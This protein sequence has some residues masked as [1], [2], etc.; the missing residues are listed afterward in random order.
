L[1]DSDW[2][3]ARRAEL[4]ASG[5]LEDSGRGANVA[6]G[7]V[8]FLSSLA[9]TG[10]YITF[11]FLGDPGLINRML[12][13][14]ML[15]LG[16]SYVHSSWYLKLPII[17]VHSNPVIAVYYNKF[18]RDLQLRGL[19]KDVIVATVYA[20]VFGS[21]VLLGIA[22]I[23]AARAKAGRVLQQFPPSVICAYLGC[24]G[25]MIV[26]ASVSMVAGGP[27]SSDPALMLTA[28]VVLMVVTGVVFLALR[29]ALGGFL[30]QIVP[31]V[32]LTA[33]FYVVVLARGLELQTLRD[34]NWVYPQPIEEPFTA[35]WSVDLSLISWTALK[36]EGIVTGLMM[37]HDDPGWLQLARRSARNVR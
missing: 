36:E 29:K 5:P 12:Q 28:P 21:T 6:I 3:R 26:Q 11:A 20:Y 15:S 1:L 2:L 10:A 4:S 18:F 33:G 34:L 32:V 7:F 24:L 37:R 19:G 27:V 13:L 16:L 23:L 14:Q 9:R 30:S 35:V 8:G 31:I 25:A 22:T 17:F